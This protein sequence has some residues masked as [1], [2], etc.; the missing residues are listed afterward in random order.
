MSGGGT[1]EVE[2]G[3]EFTTTLRATPNPGYD[4][5]RW[6]ENGTTLSN[7]ATYRMEVTGE[8]EV[9]GHLSVNQNRGAWGPGNTYT[10]YDFSG[11]GY[12]SLAWTFVHAVDPP[13]SLREKDLLH[14]YAYN[15]MLRNYTPEVG[16]G[17]AGFQSDGHLRVGSRSRW[18]KVVNFSIWGSSAARTDG[19]LNPRNEEC[20]CHQIMFQYEWVEGRAYGFE[21]R[22]GP[23]GTSA[24]W[25]WWGL[26]VT[27]PVTDSVTFIGEQRL[28]TRI[29]GR[30]STMWSPRTSVFGEDLHWWLSRNGSQR[31]VCSDFEHSSLAVLDVTAGAG[32][33]RPSRVT[34]HT[35]S[36][37]RDVAENGYE[38]TICYVT[39]FSAENGDVQ[40]NVG[41]WPEPPERVIGN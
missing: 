2:D 40:H 27:D 26:W 34:S 41:F 39:V 9:T 35:N 18:G 38:T 15:F 6:T 29:Q 12:E 7:A 8:H 11:S 1:W 20:G 23:S 10:D 24:N 5:D 36:G 31:F 19:L 37:N 14:Y 30:E 25:K 17:Y 22:E 28:P 33:R 3:Q 16:Y 13:E 21:L 4:F 32:Q